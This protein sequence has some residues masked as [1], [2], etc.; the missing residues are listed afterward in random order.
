MLAA[1][2]L[3]A[4]CNRNSDSSSMGSASDSQS[5]SKGQGASAPTASI[6]DVSSG[7]ADGSDTNG[8]AA[9]QPNNSGKNVRDRSDAA[10]T[11]GDQGSSDSDRE[12]TRRIRRAL[13]ANDQLST[14]AKNIKIIT[15][16][17]KVTLRGP[18]NNEQE[19]KQIESIVQ[20]SGVTSV[21][22]QLE[23]KTTNQ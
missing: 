9:Y 5:Q 1:V 4:G 17:G 3:I 22:D 20:Q 13:N 16:D 11:P 8:S 12:T 21:D 15:K 6:P 7:A 14:T 19:K 10:L 2:A 18:I 23:P